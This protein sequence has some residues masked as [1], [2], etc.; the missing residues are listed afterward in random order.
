MRFRCKAIESNAHNF[1]MM[2]SQTYKF[3]HIMLNLVRIQNANYPIARNIPL[4]SCSR[5]VNNALFSLLNRLFL[6]ILR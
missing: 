5:N 6:F 4:R 3:S 1:K 2:R